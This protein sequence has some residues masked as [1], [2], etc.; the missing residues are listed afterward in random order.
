MSPDSSPATAPRSE[1]S[2]GAKGSKTMTRECAGRPGQGADRQLR[3]A[4][5]AGVGQLLPAP[6]PMGARPNPGLLSP[7][8]VCYEASGSE[9]GFL[10]K[11]AHW[12][13]RRPFVAP[14]LKQD[15]E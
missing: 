8:F 10:R 11:F 4:A 6:E 1:G 7:P 2:E 9:T 15:V 13:Q 5:D 3:R 14:R 12:L